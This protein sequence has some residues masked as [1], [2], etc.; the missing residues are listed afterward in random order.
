MLAVPN[1]WASL[2]I[3]LQYDDKYIVKI[4]NPA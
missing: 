1:F 3:K 2:V 4:V